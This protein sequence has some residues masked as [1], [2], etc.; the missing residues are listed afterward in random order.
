MQFP[1]SWSVQAT[2]NLCA[3]NFSRNTLYTNRGKD[4]FQ[5]QTNDVAY[6]RLK[7]LCSSLMTHTLTK[8][9]VLVETTLDLGCMIFEVIA[10]HQ[11]II[12]KLTVANLLGKICWNS[13][14]KSWSCGSS[15]GKYRFKYG[16]LG[17]QTR[18]P[19]FEMT[20]NVLHGHIMAHL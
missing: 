9:P 1:S 13:F 18:L 12:N 4:L 16:A 10:R 2:E 14:G 7:E 8:S 15:M 6:I 17:R 5:P 20:P 19:I 11:S 3:V